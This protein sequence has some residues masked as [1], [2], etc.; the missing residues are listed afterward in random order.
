MKFMFIQHY[1]SS[2]GGISLSHAS[3]LL[4][5]NRTSYY[6]WVSCQGQ[7]PSDSTSDLAL[8]DGVQKIAVEFPRYGYR[9]I[10]IEL[11]RQGV[12]VN[13][14]KILRLMK[15]DNLLCVKKRFKPVTTDSNHGFSVYPNLIKD[16][17]I[18]QLNQVWASDITYIQLSHDFV[19][20]SVI[21]DLFSR[22]YIGWSLGRSLDTQ[23]TLNA[24]DMA[25]HT[26]WNEDITGLIHHS[27]QGVQYASHQYVEQLKTHY[28]QIS[29]SRKG[30]PY[31]NAFVESFIKTLK[32]E[33]V[34]LNEYETYRDALDNIGKFIDEVY[35][36]KRL[37]SSLEYR[38]PVEFEQEANLNSIA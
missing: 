20:L 9:R 33:E 32:W 34:Y 16:L 38:S 15:E 13:H 17:D 4:D 36:R 24:L 37:H 7:Q 27:D 26:R 28:I 22:R 1:L 14:K 5:V 19:Y 21:L 30:N 25:L 11:K 23:L 29:M 8:H 35:N 6:K 18:T 31:D 2:E 12:L 3:H 10:T